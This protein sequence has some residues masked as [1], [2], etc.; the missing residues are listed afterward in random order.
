MAGRIKT[1]TVLLTGNREGNI[2]KLLYRFR[3]VLFDFLLGFPRCI[4]RALEHDTVWTTHD[5]QNMFLC[6]ATPDA[7]PRIDITPVLVPN[8]RE[9][10]NEQCERNSAKRDSRPN[11][12]ALHDLTRYIWNFSVI[13]YGIIPSNPLAC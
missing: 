6:V 5:F 2:A 13:F 10:S 9:P 4:R 7:F 11:E 3:L 1:D 12:C 8:H